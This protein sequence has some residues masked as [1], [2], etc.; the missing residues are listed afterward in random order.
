MDSAVAISVVVAT[1]DRARHLEAMLAGLR[2]QTLA[3]D[4]FELI[5]VDDGSKD[6][7]PQILDCFYVAGAND[8]LVRFTYKDADDLERFH[9]EVLPRLSA[10]GV[11]VFPLPSLLSTLASK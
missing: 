2:A 8:Y 6:D 5:V 10:L 1:R 3:A 7:T 11:P 9:A 4:R